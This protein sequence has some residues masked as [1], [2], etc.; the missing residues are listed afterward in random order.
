MKVLQAPTT[1][2]GVAASRQG[3][4]LRARR[5]S[6]VGSA[7]GPRARLSGAGTKPHGGDGQD[8]RQ[9]HTR[10]S[11]LWA[12]LRAR[13]S[14]PWARLANDLGK[15]LGRAGK[16]DTRASQPAQRRHREGAGPS[17]GRANDRTAAGLLT[18]RRQADGTLGPAPARPVS[19][20]GPATRRGVAPDVELPPNGEEAV[21]RDPVVRCSW[22]RLAQHA[23]RSR[24]PAP[25]PSS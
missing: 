15:H 9:I 3:P 1:G 5:S 10:Q 12:R 11:I 20:G 25:V 13:P 22:P 16:T 8:P 2:K 4:G 23:S 24:C 7:S 18:C 19:G 6:V 17:R 14:K 21:T